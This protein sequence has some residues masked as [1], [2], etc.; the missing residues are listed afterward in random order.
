MPETRVHS[1][2]LFY[3]A[4]CLLALIA[5]LAVGI[6]PNMAALKELDDEIMVMKQKAET[7][8]LLF[9]VYLKMLREITRNVPVQFNVPET[10]KI[11]HHH[12]S[13]INAIFKELAA[14]NNVT[15]VSA[16]PDAVS[17]LEDS[18]DLVLDLVFRGDFFN[19]RDLLIG[20]CQLPFLASIEQL[21]IETRDE[22]KQ[23]R[24]S[25]RIKQD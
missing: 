18:N 14:G 16:R 7:Q 4:L 9:P 10:N 8:S 23:I 15:F 19:L 21:R 24:F 22:G 5:F 11:P 6:F 1:S 17:Y 13:R 3:F 12:L 2:N 20:V 25:V